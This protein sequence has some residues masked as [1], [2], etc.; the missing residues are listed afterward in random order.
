MNQSEIIAIS[1]LGGIALLLLSTGGISYFS[2]SKKE[3]EPT[4]EELAA[5]KKHE[6]K[7]S[8]GLGF[9]TDELYDELDKRKGG[10]KTMRNKRK[11]HK[12]TKKYK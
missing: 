2:K 3:Y 7:R 8:K 5:A 9:L 10:K 12:N 1:I 4:P 6:E 11:H